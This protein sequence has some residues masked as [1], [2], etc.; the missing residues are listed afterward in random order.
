MMT[1]MNHLTDPTMFE[2]FHKALTGERPG[3]TPW[4]FLLSKGLKDPVP[5]ISWKHLE[6]RLTFEQALKKMRA[7]HN[8]GIAATGMDPLCIVDVDDIEATPDEIVK[9]TLSTRSRKRIGRHYFYFTDDPRCKENLPTESKGEIRSSFEYVVA[10]GSF[11]L[12]NGETVAAMP[13]S[14]RELAGRYTVENERMPDTIVFEELPPVFLEQASKNREAGREAKKRREEKARERREK[15]AERGGGKNKSAIW[16]I[17]MDDLW[18]IPNRNRFKSLFHDSST[19]KN[20]SR[21]S[22]G[23]LSCWRHLVT[24][25]PL[26]ALCVLAGITTC[27]EAGKAMK[28]SAGGDTSIDYNDGRTVFEMWRWAKGAGIIPKDDPIPG[29][30]LRWYAVDRGICK[31]ENITDG[32]K[33]PDEAYSRVISLIEGEFDI[34]SGRVIEGEFDIP[35]GRGKGRTESRKPKAPTA[36]AQPAKIIESAV[37]DDFDLFTIVERMIGKHPICYDRTR[38]YWVWSEETKSYRLADKTDI[39]IAVK[40]ATGA[41]KGVI[42]PA[43]NMFLQAVEIIG[44]ENQPKEV[45]KEWIQFRDCVVDINTGEEFDATHEHFWVNPIPHNYGGS[46]D[47]PTIDALFDSWLGDRKEVLYEIIAYSLHRGYPIHRIFALFGSGRNGKGQFMDILGRFMGAGCTC[48]TTLELIAE[49]RFEAAKLYKKHVAFIGE[50]NFNTLKNTAQLKRLSGEDKIPGEFKQKTPFDFVNYA[51]VVIATNSIPITYDKSRGFHARWIIID[52]P[53]EFDEGVP[54]VD[55]IPEWE[56]EN[57]GRKCIRILRELLKRGKFTGEGSISDRARKYEEVSNPISKF[58]KTY[59]EVGG[60]LEVPLWKFYEEYDAW[61][62]GERHRKLTKKVV[63]GWLRDNGYEVEQHKR[64]NASD[65]WRSWRIVFGLTIGGGQADVIDPFG[66]ESDSYEKGDKCESLCGGANG[67]HGVNDDV[68]PLDFLLREK[69][70]KVRHHGH[71]GHQK[72]CGRCD[73]PLSG[74]TFHGPAG[75]GIIC[76]TCQAELAQA[77]GPDI[78]SDEQIPL[79]TRSAIYKLGYVRGLHEFTAVEALMEFPKA[80]GITVELLETYLSDH[81]ADLKIERTDS[82]TWR[83]VRST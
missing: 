70:V 18:N 57:L 45:P 71:H 76:A 60:D 33:L 41:K 55:T 22:D 8:I 74:T 53:N 39:L 66:G 3:F 1:G 27:N 72:L 15:K 61:Q 49:S 35:S 21:N 82:G 79:M 75:L 81:A 16:D 10:P 63:S 68:F 28:G 24:H 83:Q 64:K 6:G 31:Q 54:V 73:K 32:W 4:Y 38:N 19:G 42:T 23:G 13:A 26:S 25:T 52:F 51:K 80:T 47:T 77:S 48:S 44:R 69:E 17:S 14:E 65:E 5:G 11:V 62:E 29:S 30:A 40:N 59:C 43:K 36:P 46:E 56:Y 12:C 7:G 58:I 50:T 67:G 20:T 78:I 34:P 37:G 2:R 9:P